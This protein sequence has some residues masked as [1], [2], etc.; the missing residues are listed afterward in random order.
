VNQRLYE[1][2]GVGSFLLSKESKTLESL[3]PKELNV[4]YRNV[5]DCLDKIKYFLKHERERE[6]IEA[7][8]PHIV[9]MTD[10]GLAQLRREFPERFGFDAD[11]RETFY[12]QPIRPQRPGY[13]YVQLKPWP[14]PDWSE[15]LCG[16]VA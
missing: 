15:T 8:I 6:E 14:M 4:T 11:S 16:V 9:T 5:P 2:M 7:E 1:V 3:L 13:W 10:D 12:G